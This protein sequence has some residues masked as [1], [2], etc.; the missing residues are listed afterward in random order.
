MLLQHC[1]YVDVLAKTT[2]LQCNNAQNT[3]ILPLDGCC[4]KYITLVKIN[5]HAHIS[6]FM[7]LAFITFYSDCTSTKTGSCTF[8]HAVIQKI[9]R[10]KNFQ[11]L[12]SK[13][14]KT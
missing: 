4:K 6:D 7:A 9:P 1:N 5:G 8:H 3:L 14:V 13:A 11:F 2:K 10:I 12:T